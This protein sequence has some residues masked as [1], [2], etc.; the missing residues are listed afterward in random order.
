MQLASLHCRK[1]TRGF[2]LQQRTLGTPWRLGTPVLAALYPGCSSSTPPQRAPRI[3]CPSGGSRRAEGRVEISH[4][5]DGCSWEK[6]GLRDYG[7]EPIK[8]RD[9]FSPPW[10][11]ESGASAPQELICFLMRAGSFVVNNQQH[12]CPAPWGC[13]TSLGL[14]DEWY[15]LHQQ[16]PRLL[17]PPCLPSGKDNPRPDRALPILLEEHL[18]CAQLSAIPQQPPLHS[19]APFPL[20]LQGANSPGVG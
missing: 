7:Q 6:G 15:A 10:G 13:N 1:S 14:L 16:P 8:A 4:G 5:K 19:L 9:Q 20:V 11:E 2:F 12:A 17:E 3:L 18:A